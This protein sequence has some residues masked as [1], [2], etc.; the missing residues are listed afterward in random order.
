MPSAVVKGPD[1]YFYFG[2]LSGAPFPQGQSRVWKVKRGEQATLV[3]GGFT[4]I[5]D[6][7]FDRKGRLLVLEFAE[8]GLASGDP[9]GRLARLEG[10]GSQT[11]LARE[12]LRNP[13]GMA[14]APNGD[15]YISNNIRGG[16]GQGQLLRLASAA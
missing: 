13:G 2:E 5:T 11:V 14:V 7:A 15:I 12:G 16:D 9:T 10:N 4:N 3:S 8:R 6:L 1:G